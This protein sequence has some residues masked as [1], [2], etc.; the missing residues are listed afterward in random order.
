MVDPLL[1][2]LTLGGRRVSGHLGN[3]WSTWLQFECARETC[4]VSICLAD[5][6]MVDRIRQR[7]LRERGCVSIRL[8]DLVMVDPPLIVAAL[9]S[10][11]GRG[12]AGRG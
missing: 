3:L 12:S 4:S 1:R 9:S 5:L 10:H 8:A 2:G 6:V 7:T 11:D